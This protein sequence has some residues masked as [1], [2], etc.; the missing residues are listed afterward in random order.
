MN[1]LH[2]SYLFS[3]LEVRRDRTA[4]LYINGLERQA[5]GA[6]PDGGLLL[7]GTFVR[8]DERRKVWFACGGLEGLRRRH[9][10]NVFSPTHFFVEQIQLHL[11]DVKVDPAKLVAFGRA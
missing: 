11:E 7:F 9:L 4:A 2:V 8:Q 6:G 5:R 3:S 10:V 1:A